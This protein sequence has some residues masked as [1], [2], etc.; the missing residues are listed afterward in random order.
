MFINRLYCFHGNPLS[1]K[2]P[3]T[4]LPLLRHLFGII[5]EVSTEKELYLK[6]RAE[7]ICEPS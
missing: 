2:F 3:Q 5:I 7:N 1:R 4:Y 6:G